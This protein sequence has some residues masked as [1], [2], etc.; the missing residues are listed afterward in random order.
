MYGYAYIQ[1]KIALA[2][3]QD[4]NMAE[5]TQQALLTPPAARQ[6]AEY[7][8]NRYFEMVEARLPQFDAGQGC[9]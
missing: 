9:R 5:M 4:A 8:L 1:W 2:R 7:Q 6:I 3:M